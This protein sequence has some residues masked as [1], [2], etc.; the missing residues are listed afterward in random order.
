[1]RSRLGFMVVLIVCALGLVSL[2]PAQ[3]ASQLIKPTMRIEA[4]SFERTPEQMDRF[5]ATNVAPTP[6]VAPFRPTMD[7][8]AY[9]QLKQ[10]AARSPQGTRSNTPSQGPMSPP[11]I[12]S[13]FAGPN[14]C[15]AGSGCWFPPDV[16]G[17]SGG[18]QVIAVH[19]S[20]FSV[21]SSSGT[22]LKLVSLNA[23]FGYATQPFFDPRVVYDSV[24]SRWCV[25]APAFPQSSTSQILGIACSK[26]GNAL[27]SWYVYLVDVGFL[28]GPGGFYDFPM[29]GDSQDAIL[30][31]ANIFPSGSFA[32]SSLFAVAK[33][34]VFTGRGFSVPV[35][36][37]LQATLEP[38]RELL[39]GNGY[40]WLA[41]ANASG[42]IAMYALGYPAS[43]PDTQLFG[44]YN[45][46]VGAYSAPANAAQPVC[47]GGSNALNTSDARFVNM[48]IQNGDLYYQVHAIS[49]GTA[50]PR[51][52]IIKGLL[53][54]TPT[55][56]ESGLFW[57]T[58]TS[59]D[60]NASIS[61]D[62]GNRMVLNWT[63][64]DTG[65]APSNP[66]VRFTGKL[67]T[68]GVISGAVGTTLFTSAACLTGNF[69]SNFGVQ[70]W[71][72]YSQ[73][74]SDPAKS[75]QFWIENE[76]VP[77][78]NSWGTEIGRIHF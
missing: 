5:E 17:S 34:R 12:G 41:A 18:N 9:N 3:D 19:N 53:S 60:F 28:A 63:S 6:R 74:S 15:D 59:S 77:N 7:V 70:R 11:V 64:V 8:A 72:D 33:A 45:V 46:A 73:A 51:Y 37:G 2:A 1:M 61:A 67:S 68:D 58:P 25:T 76:T 65:S 44:P 66:S 56:Q 57:T 31:T 23:F 35:F 47:G 26:N 78:T 38:A 21:Y 62:G 30:F 48:G 4:V 40:A 22:Q 71:G 52:Y 42:N 69:D 20:L 55:V 32:G 27:G 75:G 50:T 29:V 24:W 49:A 14:E 13:M 39:D 36:A 43:P 16:S 10:Q 54:F